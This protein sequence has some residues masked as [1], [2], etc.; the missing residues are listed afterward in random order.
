MFGIM[1][2]ALSG[3]ANN[4][5]GS[6]DQNLSDRDSVFGTR[7][8]PSDVVTLEI[9]VMTLHSESQEQLE[10]IWRQADVQVLPFEL[11]QQLDANGI[12]VGVLGHQ[13]PAKMTQLLHINRP[14]MTSDGNLLVSSRKNLSDT[15]GQNLFSFQRLKQ[16]QLGEEY[17][18]PCAAQVPEMSWVIKNDQ[19]HRSG[20]C[21]LAECGFS[22]SH[23]LHGE[24]SIK[25]WLRP[26]IRHG[27]T[28]LRYGVDHESLL[29]TEKQEQ[30]P[31]RELNIDHP[32]RLGQ[33]LIVSSTSTPTGIGS[34]F[35]A[36]STAIDGRHLLLI[37]AVNIGPE[38]LFT[39]LPTTRRL[40]TS[41]D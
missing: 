3:C 38:D 40:A 12:R 6:L 2:I 32:L 29:I 19:S 31:L 13:L 30:L 39:P 28:K 21:Q 23:V 25:L 22:L 34:H 20:V 41:L 27:Q 7:T 5:I 11:R 10:E 15:P 33:T 9:G 26:M 24:N 35:F 17:W 4:T 8:S 18:L 36:P 14:L 37:R 16:L 1:L